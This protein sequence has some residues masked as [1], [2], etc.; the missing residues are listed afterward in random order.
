MYFLYGAIALW[1]IHEV[2]C[3]VDA[4]FPES[5]FRKWT[6][7]VVD[8]LWKGLLF[9]WLYQFAN[10]VGTVF[11]VVFENQAQLAVMIGR[12]T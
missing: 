9:W 5:I 4:V 7:Y 2:L 12:G 8:S 1:F 6:R 10:A 3:Y 11:G